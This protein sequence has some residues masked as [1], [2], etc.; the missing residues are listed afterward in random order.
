LGAIPDGCRYPDSG[1]LDSSINS[2]PLSHLFSFCSKCFKINYYFMCVDALPACMHVD[3]VHA[4]CLP[5]SEEGVGS[6]ATG[7]TDGYTEPPCRC[8]ELSLGP[9]EP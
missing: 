4:W 5:E 9:L 2:Y 8:W 6:P 1:P 3:H 7:D